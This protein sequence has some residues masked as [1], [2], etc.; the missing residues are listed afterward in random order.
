MKYK[1][2]IKSSI[3]FLF[4]FISLCSFSQIKVPIVFSELT[5]S[6][7]NGKK[8]KIFLCFLIM[9]LLMTQLFWFRIN[10]NFQVIN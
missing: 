9:I 1:F 6:P 7:A 10:Q 2:K 5:K 8:L 4:L 3:A